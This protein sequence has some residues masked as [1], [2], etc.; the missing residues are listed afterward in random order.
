MNLA[1]GTVQFGMAY[2]IAGRKAPVPENEVKAILAHAVACGVDTIDTAAAYGDIEHRLARLVDRLPLKVISKVP[3]VPAHLTPS[4]AALFAK[5]SAEQSLQRLG[6]LLHGLMLHNASDLHGERG[7]AVMDSLRPWAARHSVTLGV[8]AYGAADIESCRRDH[9]IALAQLPGNALDQR[10][11]SQ[12][13]VAT[14]QGM[15]IHLRSALLQGLLLMPL[16]D[17]CIKLPPA[18]SALQQWHAFCDETGQSPLKAALSL[19][20]SFEVVSSVVLGVDS[21][22]QWQD[23]TTAWQQATAH[24]APRLAVDAQSPIIDPRQW[25]SLA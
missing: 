1:L 6:D 21:L 9:G 2:G 19:A 7:R 17:A 13:A 24:A 3:P 15:E 11:A 20:K 4:D 5:D 23:I 25:R 16:S 8:S 12:D 22:Q 10:V 18:A 14:L